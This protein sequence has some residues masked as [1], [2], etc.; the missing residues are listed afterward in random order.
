MIFAYQCTIC[1]RKKSSQNRPLFAPRLVSPLFQC[2]CSACMP[3]R[4]FS[5]LF[6]FPLLQGCRKGGGRG[7][8]PPPIFGR[9]VNPIST[10]GGGDFVRHITKG[11]IIWKANCQAENE[12][13]NSFLLLCDVFLFVFWKRLKRHKRHFEIN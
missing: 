13:T 7:N 3:S 10:S 4:I 8:T 5:R 2:N 6:L 11:Q 9:S 1:I 12:Q